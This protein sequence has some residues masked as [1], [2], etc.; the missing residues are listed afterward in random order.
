[1]GQAR[2][3]TIMLIPDGTQT[4]REYRLRQS[5]FKLI[6][7]AT[8]ALLVGIILFFSFYGRILTRAALAD[9]LQGENQRLLRYQYKVKLLE[10]NLLQTRDIV[11]RLVKLAGIDYEF[12]EFPSDSAIFAELDRKGIAVLTRSASGDLTYPSGLPL[13]GFISKDFEIEDEE[14]YHPGLDIACSEGLPVLTT[15]SGQVIFAG[16]DDIYGNMVVIRHNDSITTVYAHNQELLV[17]VGQSV[18]VGARVALSGN[19]GKSSAPH[20]HYEIR[21]NDKPINP[22]GNKSHEK[23]KL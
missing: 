14:H 8:I 15:A 2:Y 13:Q 18:S 4:G 6:I 11:S 10:E 23:G 3:I 19:T 5:L 21:I 17:E 16:F 1:M 9:K 22:I 7:I 12:P 20:V